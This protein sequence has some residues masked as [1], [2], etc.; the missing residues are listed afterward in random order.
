V[1]A[2]PLSVKAAGAAIIP[3]QKYIGNNT[4]KEPSKNGTDAG[5][6]C[7]Y[8]SSDITYR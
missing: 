5:T 7:K 1:Q 2:L 4:G 6:Y 8:S 3:C